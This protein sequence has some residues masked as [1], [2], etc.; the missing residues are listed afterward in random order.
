MHAAGTGKSKVCVQEI[1]E[2]M[3]AS[4]LLLLSLLAAFFPQKGCC[5]IWDFSEG[6]RDGQRLQVF[7][8]GEEGSTD[9]ELVDIAGQFID[10]GIFG[11]ER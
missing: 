4:S 5:V 7:D 2:K 3:N 9:E 11:T 10:I 6:S 1:A 8:L